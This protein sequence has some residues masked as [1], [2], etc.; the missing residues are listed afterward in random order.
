[1]PLRRDEDTCTCVLGTL[2]NSFKAFETF[3]DTI[4]RTTCVRASLAVSS[5]LT[6]HASHNVCPSIASC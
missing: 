1:M 6:Y 4:I 3:E 5:S 2:S